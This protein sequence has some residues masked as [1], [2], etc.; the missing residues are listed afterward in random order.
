MNNSF[1][2]IVELARGGLKDHLD[3]TEDKT[4]AK[5]GQLGEK[6]PTAPLHLNIPV[7]RTPIDVIGRDDA[8]VQGGRNLYMKFVYSFPNN[9]IKSPHEL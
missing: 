2:V 3:Y 7:G 8:M 1:V 5:A 9:V 6:L 4:F